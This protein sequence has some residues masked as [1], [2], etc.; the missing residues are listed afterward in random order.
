MLPG[1]KRRQEA[2][3]ASSD[4]RPHQAEPQPQKAWPDPRRR[5]RQAA[6]GSDQVSC[7]NRS[8]E[9]VRS[10]S[11]RGESCQRPLYSP[12]HTPRPRVRAASQL[13]A[14]ASLELSLRSW[15]RLASWSLSSTSSWVRRVCAST[16]RDS[17]CSTAVGDQIIRPHATPGNTLPSQPR[18]AL[19]SPL[20]LAPG[21]L[22]T[23]QVDGQHGQCQADEHQQR[24]QQQE[25][26]AAVYRAA[27]G[28]GA[29]CGR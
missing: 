11:W 24:E 2:G 20:P 13:G 9:I 4:L 22:P 6:V 12:A 21:A 23:T 18:T 19:V 25:G 10:S 29:Q 28:L 5:E 15:L 17:L 8:Q 27:A 1:P 7:Q 3:V 16:R 26:P 14:W